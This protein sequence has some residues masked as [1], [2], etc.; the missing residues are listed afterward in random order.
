MDDDGK[1]VDDA[2]SAYSQPPSRYG[3]QSYTDVT[4]GT[5]QTTQASL[6]SGASTTLAASQGFTVLNNQL[7]EAMTLPAE[8]TKK[9]EVKHRELQG[10]RESTEI[11]FRDI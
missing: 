10:H 7:K 5:Q 8:K 6:M 11:R 4:R 2:E 9:I 3:K 1:S